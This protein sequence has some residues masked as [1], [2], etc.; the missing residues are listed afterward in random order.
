VVNALRFLEQRVN[1]MVDIWGLDDIAV[2]HASGDDARPDAHLLNGPQRDGTGLEQSDIDEMIDV[3]ADELEFIEA[4]M[5]ASEE[6]ST[7][8]RSANSADSVADGQP[9]AS[10]PA[11]GTVSA[12]EFTTPE[13]LNLTELDADKK[14]ALFS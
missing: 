14:A 10:S 11:T 4:E 9:V 1:A 6:V 12:V 13:D 8:S 5:P 3:A 7:P 2:R